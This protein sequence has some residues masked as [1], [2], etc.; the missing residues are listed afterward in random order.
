MH[1]LRENPGTARTFIYIHAGLTYK[2]VKM[3]KGSCIIC[4]PVFLAV[5]VSCVPGMTAQQVEA[6]T[7]AK[8]LYLSGDLAKALEAVSAENFT[9]KRG[10]QALLLKA[11]ILFL[12]G[13]TD[14]P[15]KILSDLVDE[16]PEYTEAR[17]WLA[18]TLLARGDPTA[19]ESALTRAMEFNPD[20]PRILSL[21]GN[22]R[23]IL[24]DYRQATEYYSCAALYADDLAR[25]EIS[26]AQIYYRFGQRDQALA[27]IRRAQ[28]L[29]SDN[30]VLR[31]PL[32]EAEKRMSGESSNEH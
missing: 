32:K 31:R 16:H 21:M 30:S 13:D 11:K 19:A 18:R 17:I 26:L 25:T 4:L 2:A 28:T 23:E 3:K 9:T 12:Q 7:N 15:A 24:K 22:V 10:H 27:H 8:K 6:Y 1:F 20:D 29:V 14:T 5:V